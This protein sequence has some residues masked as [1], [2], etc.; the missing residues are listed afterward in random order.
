M[1]GPF[2]NVP[3][4]GKLMKEA[5]QMGEKM[6]KV[7]EEL[8]NTQVVESSGG[9]MVTATVTG[10]G[11]VLKVKIDPAV[12]DPD[13]VEMLEDLVVTAIRQALETATGIREEKL[14]GVMPNMKGMSIPGMP[15]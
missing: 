11:E 5:Q 9:G 4:I 14:G 15:F 7:E 8:A 3:N 2:G 1:A 10:A 13:D 6:K 12:V